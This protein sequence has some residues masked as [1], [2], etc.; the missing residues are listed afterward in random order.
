[1]RSLLFYYKPFLTNIIFNVWHKCD[2][3][4]CII[5][6]NMNYVTIINIVFL[7]ISLLVSLYLFHFVFFMI[8]GLFHK[9]KFPKVEEKFHYGILVSAKDEE[10][11]IPRL[12]N[13]LRA[14]NYPQD[15]LDIFIIA[16]NCKDKTAD[17]AKS[18]GAN[19]IIY[20]DENARTLGM[21]YQHAFKQ[22]NVKD[23][24]GFIVLNADNVVSK[25]YFE[26]LNDAFV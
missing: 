1:M 20:N 15:K 23:Y 12:I 2:T 8:V 18:M 14:A 4:G 26:K 19:V 13:S 16:H 6:Y 22:I 21:A 24:D 7:I 11:V 9:R 5:F 17:V 10:N 3:N 25:D